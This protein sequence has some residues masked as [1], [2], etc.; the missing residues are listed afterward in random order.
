MLS[1]RINRCYNEA[2]A[3]I[4]VIEMPETAEQQTDKIDTIDATQVALKID[5]VGKFVK[6]SVIVYRIMVILLV[7]KT[8]CL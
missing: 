3:I 7:Y 6:R 1:K 4:E 2:I 8:I 5:C